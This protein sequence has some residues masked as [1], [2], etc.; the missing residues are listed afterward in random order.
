MSNASDLLAQAEAGAKKQLKISK[1]FRQ[2]GRFPVAT[3]WELIYSDCVILLGLNYALRYAL[4]VFSL[5]PAAY[6]DG[7][8]PSKPFLHCLPIWC[9]YSILIAASPT[10]VIS[11]A[12][13]FMTDPVLATDLTL[14]P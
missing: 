14:P 9:Y 11:S 4:R 6:Q 5:P 13:E 12:C 2:T 10:W 8:L 3:E 1:N 7:R